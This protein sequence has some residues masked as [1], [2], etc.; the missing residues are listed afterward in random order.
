MRLLKSGVSCLA[1]SLA[2]SIGAERAA[3]ADSSN[4]TQVQQVQEVIVTATKREQRLSDVPLA[5][6]VVGGDQLRQQNITS[7]AQLQYAAPELNFTAGPTASYQV[8][9][10]GTSTFSRAADNDVSVVV[11]GVIQGQLQPPTN[12][13]FDVQRV[14]VLSGPQGMLFGK[15]AA[16]GVI[17][18]VTNAPDLKGINGSAH[19]DI[20]ENGYQ[21]YQGVLNLPVSDT[22]GFRISAFSNSE[23]GLA[24][25][26]TAKQDLG[27]FTDY[28][29]RV[30]F[31]W[32]PNSAVKVNLI[33]DYERDSGGNFV[34]QVRQASGTLAYLLGL[35]GVTPGP[36]NTSTCIDGGSYEKTNSYGLSGQVDWQLGDYTVTSIT[37]DRQYTRQL[38]EDSD[39]TT[40]NILD[41]NYAGDFE[42]QFSEELRVAS[43]AGHWIDYVAGVYFYDYEYKPTVDQGGGLGALPATSPAT[44]FDQASVG[45]IR[46]FSYAAFA[47]GT[48]K[49]TDKLGLILGARQ[50][51]D[52]LAYQ[53]THYVNTKIGNPAIFIPG[54]SSASGT[55]DIGTSTD[56]FSY[57]TGLQY[58]IAADGLIYATYARG[59]KGAA[60]NSPGNAVKG[61][62][63]VAPEIPIDLEGGIKASAFERRLTI[64]FNV[65]HQTFKDFQAQ[66]A[67]TSGGITSFIF[68]N[69]S[70]L[71][72]D[73]A[74]LTL[75]ARP[76]TG[77]SLNGGLIYNKA[78]YGNFIVPCSAQYL[79][80]CVGGGVN[81]EGRQ[82]AG[83]SKWKLVLSGDYHHALNAD[84]EGFI[85]AEANYRT[86]SWT[87][88][89][90][91]PN[92]A[93]PGYALVNGRIGIR[94]SDQRYSLALF[95]KNIFD[96]R[97]PA[98]IFLDP[99]QPAS[100]YDQVFSP[101][102]FRVIG[103]SLD[104]KY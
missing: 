58:K 74:Q 9:G 38:N 47:Q 33:G 81:A 83:S 61:N 88:A 44:T 80:G 1:L 56:N 11:D 104:A 85:Q 4:S 70:R 79:V 45:K 29:G 22:A 36:K 96:K 53:N 103:V 49:L 98:L 76:M 72:V 75:T 52:V 100:G 41:Q 6:S 20:G 30:R 25:N 84:Y 69:A 57:R 16:A 62:P 63:I 91:D 50:T 65:Y 27:D 55:S 73:G 99:L 8:R 26:V 89:A 93:I 71:K 77:L 42:N 32:T 90:P 13:L 46:Q 15:N 23:S 82:L 28:G 101:D 34:W 19:A 21:I 2:C 37:A 17:N 102:A 14:E 10:V 54:L 51:H 64:D 94:T 59:Y 66:V 97:E 43:P 12:S 39:A 92:L 18:I 3:A 5:I 86:K 67:S 31:L 60:V 40:V 35:C 68:G 7:A 78:V 24:R 48:V 87:S 95:A